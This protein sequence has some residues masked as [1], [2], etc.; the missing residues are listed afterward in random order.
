MALIPRLM[1]YSS[2]RK[3]VLLAR[4]W[5]TP[6]SACLA[7]CRE[8]SS[9]AT[10][11]MRSVL[12]LKNSPESLQQ[13]SRARADAYIMDLEDAIPKGQKDS[14]LK[15]YAETMKSG[16]FRG[17]TVYV[18][19]ND[20]S[21]ETRLLKEVDALCHP[22]LTGFIV[23]KITSPDDMK[24]VDRIFS[25]LEKKNSL[26]R[27]HCKIIPILETLEALWHAP[28]IAKASP[29]MSALINGRAD[30]AACFRKPPLS[31][32]I[33]HSFM[34]DVLHAARAAGILALD[35]VSYLD[36]FPRLERDVTMG[37]ILGFDG[38]I[39]VHPSLVPYVNQL[40]SPT[41]QEIDWAEQVTAGVRIYQRSAQEHRQFIGPPHLPSASH[42]LE[43][44]SK[45]KALESSVSRN[46]KPAEDMGTVTPLQRKGGLSANPM[47]GGEWTPGIVPVTLDSSWCAVWNSSFL[48][49]RRLNSDDVAAR[50]MGLPGIQPPFHL[51]ATL[52]LSLAVSKSSEIGRFGLGISN[53]VQL[54]PVA[55]GDT[56]R[57]YFSLDSVEEAGR[58]GKYSIVTSSHVLVNQRDEVVFRATKPTMYPKK[59]TE[60]LR[61]AKKKNG[62]PTDS[63][64]R[65]HIVQN[66][67][68]RGNTYTGTMSL[69]LE[70]KKLY[71]HR[72]VKVFS[73]TEAKG[74]SNLVRATN[75]HHLN[76]KKFTTD[77]IVVA[78][79]LAEAAT[80]HNVADEFGDILYQEVVEASNVN[81]VNQED[82]IGSVSFIHSIQQLKE[83]PDLE[84]VTVRT[85]GIKN[86]DVDELM[87]RDFPVRLFCGANMKTAD[88]EKICSEEFPLL[89]RR[90]ATQVLWKF[91]RLR[92]LTSNE[93]PDGIQQEFS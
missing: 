68:L 12:F 59:A 81:R 86:L 30:I 60:K 10:P 22:D 80:V 15:L 26:P 71:V 14:A 69:P 89:Y 48:N 57:A 61:I 78:G 3:M 91:L 32:P 55:E 50:Q 11:L 29:R 40:Y 17:H 45:I 92:P 23:P 54:R 90:I 73:P 63:E 58:S 41:R 9:I 56:I 34:R 37:K 38:M 7:Q 93:V 62:I 4:Q 72:I 39:V 66:A 33:V 19:I 20:I 52:A 2:L 51:L 79:P 77:D 53:A 5:K 16:I 47:N 84:E 36:N 49:T 83:N 8:R 44:H 76:I 70:S 6:P 35:G 67:A 21:D 31:S 28:A 82:M 64:V 27:G 65:R 18:R 13:Y 25:E 42:I 88:Y 75:E 85:L 74:L 46:T 43:T 24:K 1:Q 87:D